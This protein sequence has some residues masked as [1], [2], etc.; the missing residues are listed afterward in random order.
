MIHRKR[1]AVNP[2]SRLWLLCGNIPKHAIDQKCAGYPGLFHPTAPYLFGIVL[3]EGD[4]GGPIPHRAA[5]ALD[6]IFIGAAKLFR[7]SYGT[8]LYRQIARCKHYLGVQLHFTI[9]HK[10]NRW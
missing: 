4:Q 2:A 8:I 10:R 3:K 1:I 9:N 5:Y 7:S 6:P